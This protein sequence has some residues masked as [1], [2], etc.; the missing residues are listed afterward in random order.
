MA[1]LGRNA[2]CPCGS[3]K[4]YKKCCL[5]KDEAAAEHPNTLPRDHHEHAGCP[6]C[7][8]SMIP[9]GIVSLADADEL[10]DL[11]NSVVDLVEHGRLDEAEA[12]CRELKEKFPDQIDW[13]ERG[14]IV[15][16]ARGD[17]KAAADLYRQC[18]AFT[19]D[20]DGFDDGSRAC[21][22]D[23]IKHLDPSGPLPEPPLPAQRQRL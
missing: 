3:G 5:A 16:R 12:A 20:H 22:I 15:A 4:K 2:H 14:A 10:D 7:G 19:Y 11:S 6:D 23:E 13:L 9:T 17:N 1:Q 21:M 8:Q 18:V